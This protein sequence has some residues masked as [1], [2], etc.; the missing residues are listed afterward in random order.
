MMSEKKGEQSN[1]EEA[2]NQTDDDTNC[3]AVAKQTNNNNENDRN[4]VVEVNTGEKE[5]LHI[6]D[7]GGKEMDNEFDIDSLYNHE[8]DYTDIDGT[9]DGTD[10]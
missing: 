5:G 10:N 6:N 2:W 1:N 9:V 3:E 8:Y 7:E 4:C